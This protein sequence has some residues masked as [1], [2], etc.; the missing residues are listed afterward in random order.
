MNQGLA[1]HCE[2]LQLQQDI[3]EALQRAADGEAS[4]HDI[5]LLAWASGLNADKINFN[6]EKQHA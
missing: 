6:L 3:E 2:E 5:R 4:E 1:F